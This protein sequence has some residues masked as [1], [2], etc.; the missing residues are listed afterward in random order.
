MT[1]SW[2]VQAA[3]ACA[4]LVMMFAAVAAQ[5]IALRMRSMPK[6]EAAAE[7]FVAEWA[8][9]VQASPVHKGPGLRYERAGS[10]PV[11]AAVEVLRTQDGY[12]KVMTHWHK[13]AAWVSN[14]YIKANQ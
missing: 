7:P 13:E 12:S 8:T 2:K 5:N 4:V 1:K 11:G 10:L 9:V 6:A 3:A 14:E